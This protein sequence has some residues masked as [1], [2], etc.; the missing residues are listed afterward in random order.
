M[1]EFKTVTYNAAIVDKS[2][3]TTVLLEV[4]TATQGSTQPG[5][6]R[7]RETERGERKRERETAKSDSSVII[8]LRRLNCSTRG[9][10]AGEV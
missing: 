7:E 4:S 9:I 10:R 2:R 1:L 6:E 3:Q 5:S 8:F